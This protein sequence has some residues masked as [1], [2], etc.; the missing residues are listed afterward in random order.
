MQR[1]GVCYVEADGLGSN[2][3]STVYHLYD[4]GQ[5]TY[6]LCVSVILV[7]KWVQ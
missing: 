7:L 6:S 4:I 1:L 2:P 3:V 5:V